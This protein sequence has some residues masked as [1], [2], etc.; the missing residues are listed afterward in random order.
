MNANNDQDQIACKLHCCQ[1]DLSGL[2]QLSHNDCSEQGLVL[3]RDA[4]FHWQLTD[5]GFV[6]T[7]RSSC[8]DI[9]TAL[10]PLLS[11]FLHLKQS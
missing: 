2:D 5:V 11:H 1:L 9:Q 8:C 7:T 10:K 6:C 4:A 3:D